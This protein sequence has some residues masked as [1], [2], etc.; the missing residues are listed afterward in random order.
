MSLIGAPRRTLVLAWSGVVAIIAAVLIVSRFAHPWRGITDF[1]V[2]AALA[3]ALG[4]LVLQAR[5]LRHAMPS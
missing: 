1:A 5:A 3:W 4:A 2:A